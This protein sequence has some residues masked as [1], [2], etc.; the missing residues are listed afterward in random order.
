[1]NE[2]TKKAVDLSVLI[3]SGIDCEFCDELDTERFVH[4]LVDTE[5]HQYKAGMGVSW[6]CCY[7]RMN[8]WH[9]WQGGKCPLPEGFEVEILLRHG[10]RC[11]HTMYD[12]KKLRW[13]HLSGQFD[14][15]AF[16]VVGLSDGYCYPWEIE[17]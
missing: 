8:H 4:K 5:G 15:I 17:E 9:S 10:V 12:T 13:D 16:Q 6:D 11:N 3:E 7:P 1:M 14:I 2:T